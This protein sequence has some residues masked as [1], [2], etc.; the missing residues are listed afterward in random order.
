M[1]KILTSVMAVCILAGTSFAS[2]QY[3]SSLFMMRNDTDYLQ[4][5]LF[6]F[7]LQKNVAD[8]NFSQGYLGAGIGLTGPVRLGFYLRDKESM[9]SSSP[10]T[11]TLLTNFAGIGTNAN[12]TTTTSGTWNDTSVRSLNA[13]VGFDGMKFGILG[14]FAMNQNAYGGSLNLTGTPTNSTMLEVPAVAGGMISNRLSTNY[15]GGMINNSSYV[16]T[17]TPALMMGDLMIYLPITGGIYNAR[18][19]YNLNA[20][21]E[22]MPTPTNFVFDEALL[23]IPMSNYTS[24]QISLGDFGTYRIGIA[25]MVRIISASDTIKF[26]LMGQLNIACSIMGSTTAALDYRAATTNIMLAATQITHA[27]S[28]VTYRSGYMSLPITATVYPFMLARV[29]ENIKVGIG[30]YLTGGYT[31]TSYEDAATNFTLFITNTYT[32]TLT[33]PNNNR[34]AVSIG[35]WNASA[36]LPLY[37]EVALAEFITLRVGGAVSY[38]FTSTTTTT[39][40]KVDDFQYISVST[41]TGGGSVTTNYTGPKAETASASSTYTSTLNTIFSAG[42]SFTPIKDLQIDLNLSVLGAGADI[43]NTANWGIEAIYRF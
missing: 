40:S 43:M 32:R 1:K 28:N 38:N 5:P 13:V 42:L 34:S 4:D 29:T 3:D 26:E 6:I 11:T 35:A 39:V 30:A 31:H 17:I 15:N 14:N 9:S 8:L 12:I 22:F 20:S 19:N 33:T 10:I 7:K 37:T 18:T 36:A 23:R 41:N 24:N 21:N 16:L 27:I 2:L 25:P